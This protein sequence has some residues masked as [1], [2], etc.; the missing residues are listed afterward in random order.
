MG[1]ANNVSKVSEKTPANN[2]LIQSGR[3]HGGQVAA[4]SGATGQIYSDDSSC[5]YGGS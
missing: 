1:G 4:N 5:V 3:K 2:K